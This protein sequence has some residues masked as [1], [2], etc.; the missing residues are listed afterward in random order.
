[1]IEKRIYDSKKGVLQLT[2]N[3][4]IISGDLYAL[5]QHMFK[6]DITG[7]LK[8]D[9]YY[10]R[11][12]LDKG[13]NKVVAF[14]AP[15]T[16]HNN[17]KV[18]NFVD[19]DEVKKWFG[20]MTTCIVLNAWDTT[21]ESMNGADF[22][23][24]AFISTNNEVLLKNTKTLL[25]IICEQKTAKKQVI[26]EKLLRNSNKNGF[27]NDVGGVTNK[28]T[29]MFDVLA[30][31][32]KD[33]KDYNEMIYR[34]VCMQ[35]YQQEV[36]DSVKGIIAKQVP[37][38]WYDYKALKIKPGDTE[39]IIEWKNNQLRLASYK[40]PYFFIYNYKYVMDRY[41]KYI[42]DSNTNSL[43]RFGITVDELYKKENKTED[44]LN[45]IKYYELLIPVFMSKSTMNR[46]CW[47]LEDRFKDVR[48]I[49]TSSKQ[50]DTSIMKSKY[51]Y[52]QSKFN[53]IK[54]IYNEYKSDV[55][56]F[57]ITS[58][59]MKPEEKREKRSMFVKRYKN[60]LYK[61]CGNKYVLSNILIDMCYSNNNS[62]QFVWD[63]CG[64]TIIENLLEKNNNIINYPIIVDD[65]EDFTWNGDKYKMIQ[66]EFNEDGDF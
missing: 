22:D 56:Q 31:L 25:P 64:K 28:C 45:F 47:A 32:E 26:T 39:E 27:D 37:K 65:N 3:Y 30:T 13:V 60:K 53:E 7:L 8:K 34:I 42:Q 61:V 50:F 19:N 49:I 54:E 62:K 21:T 23:S 12:W 66:K 18:M 11:T 15:M 63:I 4:S 55:R 41:K 43:I 29:G 10:S 1:M 20:N 17:I 5:C 35:G 57:M 48:L 51:I 40:K 6:M 33:S 36:I 58:K 44:E 46:I 16:N 24:D 38:H 9:E 52:A 2:A 59:H 14:R